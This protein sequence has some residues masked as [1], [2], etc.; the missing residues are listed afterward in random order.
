MP[1][2]WYASKN[3]SPYNL[4]LYIRKKSCMQVQ[5]PHSAGVGSVFMSCFSKQSETPGVGWLS[6][7]SQAFQHC[8]KLVQP[9]QKYHFIN[10]NLLYV[11]MLIKSENPGELHKITSCDSLEYI[12]QEKQ[13]KK[14]SHTTLA[15]M[16]CY[17]SSLV[18]SK[19]VFLIYLHNYSCSA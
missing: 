6:S 2:S 10:W 14:T 4:N 13:I 7:F 3:C 11:S 12:G 8:S 16:L 5:Q 19:S 9:T 15:S 18:I 17:L 1:L